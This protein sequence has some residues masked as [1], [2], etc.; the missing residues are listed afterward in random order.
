MNEENKN[1]ES[2]KQATNAAQNPTAQGTAI[3]G[4]GAGIGTTQPVQQKEKISELDL[5]KWGFRA[6]AVGGF[7]V[8]CFLFFVLQKI[9]SNLSSINPWIILPSLLTPTL[10]ILGLIWGIVKLCNPT[11]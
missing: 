5:R 4:G 8:I 11:E 7:L 6:L 1:Q 3:K 9:F 10:V 2:G